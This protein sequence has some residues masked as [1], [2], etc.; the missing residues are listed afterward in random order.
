MAFPTLLLPGRSYTS[1]SAFRFLTSPWHAFFQQMARALSLKTLKSRME[2]SDTIIPA[3]LS[4]ASR[5]QHRPFASLLK[6]SW[7]DNV[8]RLFKTVGEWDAVAVEQGRKLLYETSVK[9]Q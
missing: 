3:P 2:G 8:E 1:T 7:N 6:S 4:A 5:I 9:R